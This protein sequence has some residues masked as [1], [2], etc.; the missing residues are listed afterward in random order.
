MLV[1]NATK[2]FAWWVNMLV[3]H[4]WWCRISLVSSMAAM[5]HVTP[6]VKPHCRGLW[7]LISAGLEACSICF[8][9]IFPTNNIMVIL[10]NLSGCVWAPFFGA[11]VDSLSLGSSGSFPFDRI[12]LIRLV[13]RGSRMAEANLKCLLVTP[14]LSADLVFES[15]LINFWT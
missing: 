5:L 9:I 8:S 4:N 10:L 13:S 15:G 3:L 12:L 2:Y 14:K 1:G 7:W 11:G 6:S